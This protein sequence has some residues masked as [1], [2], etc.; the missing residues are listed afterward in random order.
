MPKK[1]ERKKTTVFLDPT[2]LLAARKHA[3]DRGV[4]LQDLVAEGLRLVL[5]KGGTA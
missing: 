3:L 5:K 1:P 2:L 4:T